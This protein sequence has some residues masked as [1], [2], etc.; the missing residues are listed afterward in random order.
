MSSISLTDFHPWP[1]LAVLGAWASLGFVVGA[2]YFRALWRTTL[3][4]TE[5]GHGAATAALTVLRLALL[6][7]SLVVATLQGPL[8]LM[9][10][11]LGL[12]VAK[13]VV[14]RR[15]KGTTP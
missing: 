6:V 13:I 3:W 1:D 8:P 4:L 9:A 14:V 11:A 2:V 7:G 5:A 12:I 10:T 15:V